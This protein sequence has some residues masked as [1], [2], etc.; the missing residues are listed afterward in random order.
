VAFVDILED[1]SLALVERMADIG[2]RPIF[3]RQ[4]VTDFATLK[5]G[6]TG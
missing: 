6:I 2:P 5:D 1:E 4:D 3:A